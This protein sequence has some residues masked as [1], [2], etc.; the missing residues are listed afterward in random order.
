M[1]PDFPSDDDGDALRRVFEFG[2]DPS[3]PMQIDFMVD[4][5]SEMAGNRVAASASQRGYQASVEMD[6][7]AGTWTC[8]CSREMLANYPDIQAAQAELDALAQPHGGQID[9]WGTFGN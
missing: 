8:Y 3:R 4:V 2:A 1:P 7:E 9:G 5:P 6:P